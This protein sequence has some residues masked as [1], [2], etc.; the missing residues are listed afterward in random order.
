M[1]RLTKEEQD[2]MKMSCIDSFNV[3]RNNNWLQYVSILTYRYYGCKGSDEDT[4]WL[5]KLYDFWQR[6]MQNNIECKFSKIEYLEDDKY[7]EI[8]E[9]VKAYGLDVEKFWYLLLF[10]YD[11]VSNKL[12]NSNIVTDISTVAFAHHLMEQFDN[13]EVEDLE[14]IIKLKGKNVP[15]SDAG[16]ISIVTM[17]LEGYLHLY[18]DYVGYDFCYSNLN[19]NTNFKYSYHMTMAV[20]MYKYTFDYLDNEWNLINID[21]SAEVSLNKM[22]L[23]SQIIHL[24]RWTDNDNFLFDDSALKGILKSYKPKQLPLIHSDIY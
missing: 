10:V 23:I 18:K 14:I 21:K 11:Y 1:E 16:K 20:E 12:S 5:S 19:N 15:I 4:A 22:F 6:Y 7:S 13:N 24:Y 17:L 9:A 8:R 3:A 2:L